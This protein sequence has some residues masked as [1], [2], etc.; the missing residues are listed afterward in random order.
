MASMCEWVRKAKNERKGKER[1]KTTTVYTPCM[2]R[3]RD[4]YS[5]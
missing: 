2:K 3:E 4:G 5:T 1:R